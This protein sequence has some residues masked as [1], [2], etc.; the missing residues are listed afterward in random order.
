M[1]NKIKSRR[2]IKK[3]LKSRR[4]IKKSL[5]SRRKIH[6][7]DGL[8]KSKSK[9]SKNI[10]IKNVTKKKCPICNYYLSVKSSHCYNCG[11]NCLN[12]K[13]K[14]V[15]NLIDCTYYIKKEFESQTTINKGYLFIDFD[16]TIAFDDTDDTSDDTPIYKKYK[17]IHAIESPEDSHTKLLDTSLILLKYFTSINKDQKIFIVSRGSDNTR[18]GIVEY[19]NNLYNVE[20][21]YKKIPHL[22][23]SKD[24]NSK[25]DFIQFKDQKD[26]LIFFVDNNIEEHESVYI[27]YIKNLDMLVKNNI[28]LYSIFLNRIADF[29]LELE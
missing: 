22:L 19:L 18:H 3:S 24:Y 20:Y 17:K 16:D 5:K 14:Q 10:E 2:K 6:K 29:E 27:E 21:I 4:K 1:I 23:Y 28:H 9:S 11:K 26:L 15:D 7:K 25:I 8:S 12:Y 13:F